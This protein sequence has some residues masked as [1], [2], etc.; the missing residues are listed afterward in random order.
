MSISW[1]KL[2]QDEQDALVTLSKSPTFRVPSQMAKRF[3]EHTLI[4]Q[5]GGGY[6]VLTAEGKKLLHS[7]VSVRSQEPAESSI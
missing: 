7:R 4:E 6:A 5:K 2:S 3:M 1:T